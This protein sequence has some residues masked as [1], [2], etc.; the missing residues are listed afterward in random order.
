MKLMPQFD[1]NQSASALALIEAL[2]WGDVD[3]ALR[4]MEEALRLAM[5]ATRAEFRHWEDELGPSLDAEH[6]W[7]EFSLPARHVDRMDP[8]AKLAYLARLLRSL[9]MAY[10]VSTD[11]DATASSHVGLVGPEDPN[12]PAA[13]LR[14]LNDILWMPSASS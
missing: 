7:D 5:E 3:G 4:L 8:N 9:A 2:P 13:L 11:Y 14:G 12:S 6:G 10:G 1:D